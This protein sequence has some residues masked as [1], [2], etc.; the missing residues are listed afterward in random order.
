VAS[1]VHPATRKP[2]SGLRYILAAFSFA[3]AFMAIGGATVHVA[4]AGGPTP[5]AAASL[6][7]EAAAGPRSDIVDRNGELLA[8]TLTTHSLFADPT[9][10]WDAEETASALARAL[11][12]LDAAA[13]ARRIAEGASAG[14]RFVWIERNLSPRQRQSVFDLGLAGLDFVEEPR[15]VY[16]RGRL[17]AHVLGWTNIDGE[18]AAGAERAFDA[19]LARGDGRPLA[20]SIDLRVQFALDD[21]LRAAVSEF[22]AEAGVGIVSDVRSGEILAMVS[23][24]DFDPNRPGDSD[25]DA[26]FNRAMAAVYELG[27]I[28]KTFTVATA[29]DV[30]AAGLDTLLPT[31]RPLEVA[32]RTITDSA[33]ADH[34][35]SV[36]EA[37]IASSNVGV[38]ALGLGLDP[39]VQR[40]YL[41]RFGLLD[42]A[43]V[44][45]IESARPLVPATWGDSERAT[46]SFGHG[47]AV[48][49]VAFMAGFDAA[50]NGG[51]YVRPT[52]RPAS[53]RG[54]VSEPV[55]APETSV[56]IAQ[57][58]RA[59]VAV[60]TGRRADVPGLGVGGKTGT[61]EKPVAGG[62]DPDRLV[63][64][65][66]A[67]FPFDDPRYAILVLLDEPQGTDETHGRAGAGYTA[68]PTAAAVA[69]R[70]APLLGVAQGVAGDPQIA[71]FERTA[72]PGPGVS[73]EDEMR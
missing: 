56:E 42:R 9:R 31:D 46:V 44:D 30:E 70:I 69:A 59:V 52:L 2:E 51:R 22:Q 53:A 38:G 49:P 8:S 10:V 57:L 61:A 35:L 1:S 58:L 63:A 60:G 33:P 48:S 39:V 14:R 28:F 37:F 16:P 62:Y 11:P 12:G 41:G 32:G 4:L 29:L 27:S 43:P 67:V 6:A 36:A 18:G 50:V 19:E 3:L 34:E 5:V 45:Y 65:F 71:A 7:G 24:P 73:L 40:D 15:R 66:A 55:L 68:A 25:D 47:I 26:R 21:E 13:T 72:A 54:A 20:L 17:A 64:S 23:L